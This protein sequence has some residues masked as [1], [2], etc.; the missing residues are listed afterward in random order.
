[1]IAD[2]SCAERGCICHDPREGPGVLMTEKREWQNLTDTELR[3]LE[4]EFNAERV[5]TSD[6][7][8]LVIYPGDYYAWMRAIEAKLREKNT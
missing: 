7:E 3:D 6:E 8:Y 5:R 2:P 1:M 4:K